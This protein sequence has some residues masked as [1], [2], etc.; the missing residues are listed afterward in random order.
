MKKLLFI[1][2]I[3]LLSSCCPSKVEQTYYVVD[4]IKS[5]GDSAGIFCSYGLG[6]ERYA[7]DTVNKFK[8]GDTL[9]FG[10]RVRTVVDSTELNNTIS[11]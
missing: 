1:F 6:A 4:R 2:S 7:V 11:F 8:I 10:V 9:V 5:V 3:A